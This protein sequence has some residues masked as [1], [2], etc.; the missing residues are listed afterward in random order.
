MRPSVAA[1]P[2]AVEVS[3]SVANR[4]SAVQAPP[5]CRWATIEESW[6]I[7]KTVPPSRRET[8]RLRPSPFAGEVRSAGPRRGVAYLHLQ[9]VAGDVE[10]PPSGENARGRGES[11][12]RLGNGSRRPVA[13]SQ[14]ADLDGPVEHPGH[15]DEGPAIRGE[16][17]VLGRSASGPRDVDAAG[18]RGRVPDPDVTHRVGRRDGPT[19][20]GVRDPFDF[21]PVPDQRGPRTSRRDVPELDRPIHAARGERTAVRGVGQARH[22]EAMAAARRWRGGGAQVP[23]LEAAVT[24]RERPA[25]R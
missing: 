10:G 5:S 12:A 18:P 19:V 3:P 7:W 1:Q 15:Q 24:R 17:Q 13:T 22:L 4:P 9:T 6:V 8:S 11:A 23:E 14:A 20:R 16:G 21:G 25:V 2:I